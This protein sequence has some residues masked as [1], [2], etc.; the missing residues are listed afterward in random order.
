M[1]SAK[2]DLDK[3]TLELE[4]YK[5]LYTTM[6]NIGNQRFIAAGLLYATAG[7]IAGKAAELT[8]FGAKASLVIVLGVIALA[9]G[10]IVGRLSAATR[11]LLEMCRRVEEELGVRSGLGMGFLD[12]LKRH[13]GQTGSDAALLTVYL[14]CGLTALGGPALLV[15]H[16]EGQG[17]FGQVLGLVASVI[18][19]GA[20]VFESIQLIRLQRAWNEAIAQGRIS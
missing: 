16:L 10:E 1:D 20:G 18:A 17:L 6:N 14:L 19:F 8:S 2:P 13:P 7:V 5:M 12:Y 11:N 15:G 3:R 9:A 4:G